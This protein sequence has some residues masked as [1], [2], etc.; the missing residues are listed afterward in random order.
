MVISGR[1]VIRLV[2]RICLGKRGR[3]VRKI[4]A[5]AILNIL[6]K[7]ALVAMNTYLRVLAKVLIQ[8]HNIG[9][10]LGDIYGTID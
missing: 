10:L 2:K 1:S 8:Q 4:D 6:P 5:P 9:G 7:L 3:N